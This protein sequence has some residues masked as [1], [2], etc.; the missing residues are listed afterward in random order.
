[1]VRHIA[2]AALAT[3]LSAGCHRDPTAAAAR[4]VA[5]AAQYA[6][7]QQFSQAII[8]YRNALKLQPD[9]AA[10]QFALATAYDAIGNAQEAVAAFE[11]AADLDPLNIGARL[12]LAASFFYA[13]QFDDAERYAQQALAIDSHLAPA[14]AALAGI[15]IAHGFVAAGHREYDE[16]VR[17]Q[18][19]SAVTS[20]L[21]GLALLSSGHAVDARPLLEQSVRLDPQSVTTWAALSD[22]RIRVADVAGAEDALQHALALAPHAVWLFR[23]AA[24]LH[25]STDHPERAERY[26]VDAAAVSP[27]DRLALVDYYLL[28]HRPEAARSAL[29]GIP[30]DPALGGLV[31]L[32]QAAIAHDERHTDEYQQLLSKA[33]AN[34]SAEAGAKLLR[35]RLLISDGAV[36]RARDSADELVRERPEAPDVLYMH[37]IVSAARGELE[38]AADD[39]RHAGQRGADKAIV[40]RALAWLAQ[41]Y[42][43]RGIGEEAAHHPEQARRSYQRA[44]EFNPSAGIAA[45]NLAWIYARGGDVVRALDFALEAD[46]VLPQMPQVQHTTGWMYHLMRQDDRAL[47][48]LK[49]AIAESPNNPLYRRDY[50]TIADARSSTLR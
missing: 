2:G 43:A 39:F 18:S 4:V 35:I 41:A 26:L 29:L 17:G 13:G 31:L 9:N 16:I 21:F 44:L 14:R 48:F 11:R 24:V 45:N 32:R 1:M 23:R 37:G 28:H 34:P 20:R 30:H 27:I 8:D 42:V 10:A 25:Q 19:A 38:S 7:H 33:L 50:A 36:D 6:A 46:R 47:E 15:T 40:N 22:A 3:F 5:R 49:R 12:S